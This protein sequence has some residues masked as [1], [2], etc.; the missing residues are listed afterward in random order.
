M[1]NF[2]HQQRNS[3]GPEPAVFGLEVPY[4]LGHMTCNS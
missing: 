3:G 4:P 1:E 2:A